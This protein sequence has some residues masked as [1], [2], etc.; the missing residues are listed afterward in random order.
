VAF[1]AL[2]WLPDSPKH[3][4][5][6]DTTAEREWAEQRVLLDRLPQSQR[7]DGEEGAELLAD[8]GDDEDD[9]GKRRVT[10]GKATVG[11][12]AVL[13]KQDIIDAVK[14]WRIWWI[15]GCN[16]SSSVPGMAFSVF[17]P[18]VV[19]VRSLHSLLILNGVDKDRALATQPSLQ[20]SLLFPPSSLV[21]VRSF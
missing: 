5:W 19:K 15:L 16:I 21:P 11:G 1:T 7:R 14:D 20:T 4:W 10:S 17:L 3:A 12:E 9:A 13:T 2:F 6:L 8:D 18:L